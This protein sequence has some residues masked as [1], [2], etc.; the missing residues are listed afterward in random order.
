MKMGQTFSVSLCVGIALLFLWQILL[1]SNNT[2]YL[3]DVNFIDFVFHYAKPNQSLADFLTRLF[4]VDNNHMAVVPKIELCIQFEWFHDINFKR[5]LLINLTKITLIGTWFLWQFKQA[6]KPYWMALPLVL[7]WFQPQYYEISNWAM[8]GSTQ[9]SVLLFSLLSLEC[10]AKPEKKYF[11]LANIFAGL[12][13]YS[14]ASGILAFAGIGFFLL[15]NKRHREIFWLIP[16]PALLLGSY[17]YMKQFGT[18]ADTAH[19]QLSNAI[20]FFLN[21]VGTIAMVTSSYATEAA[22]VAGGILTA[23]G[24]I[25]LLKIN[26]QS[27]IA[28]LLVILLANC[29][30]IVISREGLGIFMVSRFATLSPLIAMSVYLLYLP[31]ISNKIALCTLTI[32]SIFWIGSYMQYLPVMYQQKHQSTAE[33]ANWSRNR[34]WTYATET[35]Q[36][37]ASGV[38]IPSYHQGLWKSENTLL[39]DNQFV[40]CLQAKNLNLKISEENQ[41]IKVNNFPW[42]PS[43]S[44]PFFL[45]F[46]HTH[47]HQKAYVKSIDFKTNSKKNLLFTGEW[48]MNEGVINMQNAQMVK[49]TYQIYLYDSVQELYWKTTQTFTR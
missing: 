21:L 23:L 16:L 36:L 24:L 8:T 18:V 48:L 22:W 44:H 45:I 15:V 34:T 38:L 14:F 35:F 26:Y 42:K 39:D 11:I 43:L 17:L 27:K 28:A 25:G 33:A 1:V 3:D 9:S 47:L 6:N 41:E 10:I 2:P 12:A 13:F 20:P 40:K 4:T 32:A 7:F 19:I 49:G 30:L 29:L 46:I 31:R 37:Y 5:I